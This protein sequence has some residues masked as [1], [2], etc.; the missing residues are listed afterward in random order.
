MNDRAND[1]AIQAGGFYAK[2]RWQS[3]LMSLID[4]GSADADEKLRCLRAAL[5][6]FGDHLSV[7]EILEEVE[8]D[9][10][11][12]LTPSGRTIWLLF[13]ETD[14]LFYFHTAES[15]ERGCGKAGKFTKIRSAAE[16]WEVVKGL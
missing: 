7:T 3:E 6:T 1:E 4:A 9:R 13:D 15:F 10:I 2:A 16:L 12:I 11:K 5:E 8:R 14:F